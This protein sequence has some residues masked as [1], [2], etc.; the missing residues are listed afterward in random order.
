MPFRDGTAEM[1]AQ[2][3]GHGVEGRWVSGKRLNIG[4]GAGSFGRLVAAAISGD[5][6]RVGSIVEA[7]RAVLVQPLISD[8]ADLIIEAATEQLEAEKVDAAEDAEDE[9]EAVVEPTPAPI[10][11]EVVVQKSMPVTQ[12]TANPDPSTLPQ[13]GTVNQIVTTA[14]A[15]FG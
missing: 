13:N 1:S 8:E 10:P 9:E 15:K 3:A 5:V 7:A 12:R 11:T 2:L 6:Q 14:S 4:D